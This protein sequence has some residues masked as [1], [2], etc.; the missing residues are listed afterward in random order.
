MTKTK[1]TTKSKP[2]AGKAAKTQ[3]KTIKDWVTL[4]EIRNTD[5]CSTEYR[6]FLRAM[7]LKPTSRK[8][9][10]LLDILNS[11]PGQ[12]PL[13]YRGLQ[14]VQWLTKAAGACGLKR[15]QGLYYKAYDREYNR[16]YSPERPRDQVA[17][18]AFRAV[19][20]PKKRAR[21]SA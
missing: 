8:R 6:A 15:F 10:P 12:H 3:R 17:E 13:A 20:E 11:E 16:E 4:A 7:D 9:I 19:L 5:P 14:R 21:K 1:K 18:S 2:A